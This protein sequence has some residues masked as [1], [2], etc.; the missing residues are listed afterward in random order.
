MGL[1]SKA[2][3]SYFKTRLVR[4]TQIRDRG[5]VTCGRYKGYV[6]E[7]QGV[8]RDN[9]FWGTPPCLFHWQVNPDGAS[10]ISEGAVVALHPR[11][12]HQKVCSRLP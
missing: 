2:S 12:W 4:K 10:P 3:E 8:G 6:T 11:A 5:Y 9:L 1:G 7:R